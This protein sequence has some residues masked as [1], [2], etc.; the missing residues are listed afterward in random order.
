[1]QTKIETLTTLV[2]EGA[3]VQ[4]MTY[5]V[6]NKFP[7]RYIERCHALFMDSKGEWLESMLAPVPAEADTVTERREQIAA[8]MKRDREASKVSIKDI[9]KQVAGHITAKR[10]DEAR[11]LELKYGES[12]LYNNHL[13]PTS[14]YAMWKKRRRMEVI[15]EYRWLLCGSPEEAEA[16]RKAHGIDSS[17]MSAARK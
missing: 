14:K 11:K 3:L 9:A 1:M 16:Y 4:A 7:T 12:V 5:A 2:E 13:K 15:N 10:Y 8:D 17:E 6:L